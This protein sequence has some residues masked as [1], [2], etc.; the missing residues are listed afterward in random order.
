MRKI[1]L[2][3]AL[4]ACAIGFLLIPIARLIDLA[5]GQRYYIMDTVLLTG[6]LVWFASLLIIMYGYVLPWLRE[7][8]LR[9]F[10]LEPR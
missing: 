9:L 6:L 2:R 3:V 8:L 7:N 5:I 10:R 1:S 4:I